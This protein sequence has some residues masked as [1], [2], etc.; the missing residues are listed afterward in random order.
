MTRPKF[1][2][3][4][5]PRKRHPTP[6]QL[7]GLDDRILAALDGHSGRTVKAVADELGFSYNTIRSRLRNLE[8]DK[9]VTSIG[10]D[11]SD[12]DAYRRLWKLANGINASAAP[13]VRA[14]PA[15]WASAL[16][17]GMEAAC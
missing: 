4:G 15:T 11:S 2:Y 5:R 7:A 16:Y 1:D 9:K 3:P 10:A 6:E 13:G 14:A 8:L 12:K 17:G